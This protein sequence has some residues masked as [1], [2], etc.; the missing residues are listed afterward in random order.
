LS[1]STRS[2]RKRAA[3][4]RTRAASPYQRIYRVVRGIP[5][6]RVATY[7]Q[8]AAL[9]KA[10]GPRQVG[11][12]LHALPAGSK[13]PWHRVVNS[14]GRISL[15]SALGG[16]NYQ[17][18]LLERERVAFGPRGNIDLDRFQWER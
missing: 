5:R 17:R 6:G 1:A 13:V 14:Q 2:K 8:I 16:E 9:A 12:A 10:S 18:A 3:D 7:G 15:R 11:Y 4:R